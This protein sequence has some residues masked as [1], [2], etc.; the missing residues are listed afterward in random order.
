MEGTLG[1][2]ESNHDF[3]T[4]RTIKIKFIVD[5]E[6]LKRSFWMSC[7]VDNV[8]LGPQFSAVF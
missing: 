2:K 4:H 5:L 6:I 3:V 7:N 1:S 8:I